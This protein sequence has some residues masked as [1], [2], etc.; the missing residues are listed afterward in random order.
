MNDKKTQLLNQKEVA[1]H[2]WPLSASLVIMA[3]L[4]YASKVRY[5]PPTVYPQPVYPHIYATTIQ[6]P[7]WLFST[8]A[9][10]AAIGLL[11]P[12]A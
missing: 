2:L 1:P 5:S 10:Q 8:E 6:R 3:D 7:R 9:G 4:G 11:V 12:T